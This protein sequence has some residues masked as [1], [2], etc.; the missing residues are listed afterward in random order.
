MNHKRL[1]FNGFLIFKINFNGFWNL[2]N[3]NFSQK[4]SLNCIFFKKLTSNRFLQIK[5]SIFQ[6]NFHIHSTHFLFMPLIHA[7]IPVSQSFSIILTNNLRVCLT[8][9]VQARSFDD[10]SYTYDCLLKWWENFG[11]FA[12]RM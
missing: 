2:K 9:L 5:S 8:C 10:E 3:Q 1:I 4:F 6:K 11:L 12:W 7:S